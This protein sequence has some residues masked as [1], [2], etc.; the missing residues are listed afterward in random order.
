MNEKFF[1]DLDNFLSGQTLELSLILK[2]G[3]KEKMF[4]KNS[5]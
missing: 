4:F 2:C 5:I 3:F 1:N